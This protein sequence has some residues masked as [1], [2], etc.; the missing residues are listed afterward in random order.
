MTETSLLPKIAAGQ[1]AVVANHNLHSLYLYQRRKDMRAFYAQADLIE[2][3]STPLIAWGRLLGNA[4]SGE[5]RVTYLDYRETFWARAQN[6]GWRVYH[7]GGAA[8][9]NDY[10]RAAILARYPGVHVDVHTGFFDMNGAENDA[11]I[12]DIHDKKPDILFV[13]MGMPRQEMWI[14]ANRHRLPP[15][16]ILPVGAAFD[17]EAGVQYAPPRWTGKVGLEWLFRFAADPQRLFERYFVEPWFLIPQMVKDL[18]RRG[19]TPKRSIFD[20][21]P[22]FG[23]P[24]PGVSTVRVSH[25]ESPHQPV[26][27][28]KTGS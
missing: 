16:V 27:R 23:S 6:L 25:T 15:C 18:S 8:E 2:I 7:V 19:K 10:S 12:G 9:H 5:H 28:R 14:L 3:D 4:L 13:G 22:T 21:R 17:Y 26:A 20:V 11:L 1:G 24:P